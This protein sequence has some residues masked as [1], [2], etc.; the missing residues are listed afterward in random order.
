MTKRQA[1]IRLLSVLFILLIWPAMSVGAATQAPI[2]AEASSL[3]A[4]SGASTVCARAGLRL[5]TGPS[6]GYAIVLVLGYGETVYPTGA[7][8][9]SDGLSWTPVYVHRPYGTSYGYCATMYLCGASGSPGSVRVTAQAGLRLRWG[10]GLGYGIGRV[11]PYGTYLT[12]TGATR[13]GSGL[14]WTQVSYRGGYYW[15]ASYYLSNS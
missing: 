10:A 12:P 13:W 4:A 15:A 11:V 9:W 2:E 6:R 7:P 3:A 5:R 14:Q 1:V 8:V